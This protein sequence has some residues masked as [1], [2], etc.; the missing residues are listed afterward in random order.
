MPNKSETKN[1]DSERILKTRMDKTKRLRFGNN[2][3]EETKEYNSEEEAD[4]KAESSPQNNYDLFMKEQ[5]LSKDDI[6]ER[7][8]EVFHQTQMLNNDSPIIKG[9]GKMGAIISNIN[10]NLKDLDSSSNQE[11]IGVSDGKRIIENMNQNMLNLQKKMEI[12]AND[13]EDIR[14]KLFPIAEKIALIE[15]IKNPY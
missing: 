11:N 10:E 7:M 9:L 14:G 2:I 8:S 3:K 4:I 15:L 5:I 12:L 1:K 6:L 13:Y